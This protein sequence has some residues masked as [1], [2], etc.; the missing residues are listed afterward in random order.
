MF[1]FSIVNKMDK[2][3]FAEMKT[4]IDYVIA[5]TISKYFLVPIIF[6]DSCVDLLAY[7]LSKHCTLYSNLPKQQKFN[8]FWKNY[9][10]YM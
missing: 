6:T 5:R 4:S 9:Y 1:S 10:M 3:C 2:T 7:D 8:N